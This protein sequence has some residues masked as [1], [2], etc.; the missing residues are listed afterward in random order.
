MFRITKNRTMIKHWQ[1]PT[2][3]LGNK[4]SRQ[5]FCC[6]IHFPPS[7]LPFYCKLNWRL[8]VPILV[9]YLFTDPGRAELWI[10]HQQESVNKTFWCRRK[11]INET[12][13]G[14]RLQH[15]CFWPKPSFRLAFA[16]F[17]LTAL[18]K[19]IRSWSADWTETMF[20]EDRQATGKCHF[21]I[22]HV[23]HHRQ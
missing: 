16:E 4:S 13:M 3:T 5:V 22:P 17:E 14:R 20:V 15:I 9:K 18:C 19:V 23:I 6:S 2:F 12:M 11:E 10:I 8:R 21:H 1:V 7:K